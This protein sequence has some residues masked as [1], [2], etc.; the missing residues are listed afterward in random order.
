MKFYRVAIL[1]FYSLLV[2]QVFS[3]SSSKKT[4][5]VKRLPAT[6]EDVINDF[7]KYN[8]H[9]GC[10]EGETIASIGAG[11]G[12]K[13]AQI[14]CFVDGINWY[15]EDIDSTKLYQFPKVHDYHEQLKGA[16]IQAEFNLILGTE[17]DPMLPHG[18]FD[19]V[20]MMN[21]FHEIESRERIMLEISQLLK[22][23][24]EL[25]IMERMAKKSGE[26]HGDCKYPKLFESTFLKEMN[27]YGFIY[28]NVELAEE[29]SNLTY[30][31][32]ER[33]FE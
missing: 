10:K 13:E 2:I 29:M 33:S 7:E 12:I 28:K 30:Y 26:V 32:F 15:L 5:N 8:K 9:N 3:C 27:G 17:S 18:V 22:T 4:F 1:F 16:P 24:G 11:N 25:V 14:S 19:R 31:T 21:V 6:Y 20:L 23:Q